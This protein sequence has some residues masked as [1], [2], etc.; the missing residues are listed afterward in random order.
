MPL[1]NRIP[2]AVLCH[3]ESSP[4]LRHGTTFAQ[5]H[6]ADTG[7]PHSPLQLVELERSIAVWKLEL[8]P[9]AGRL[10]ARISRR[11]AALQAPEECGE[12]Q[13]QTVQDRILALTIDGGEPRLG[14]AQFRELRV[15]LA[16]RERDA[17]AR[18]GIAAL[19]EQRVV[20]LAG[21]AQHRHERA[22]LRAGRVEPDFV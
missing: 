9:P 4:K 7:H 13:I 14:F 19:L 3:E 1:E 8:I 20:E 22:L 18:P 12:G 15:L 5:A 10:E 6:R 21:D 11:L 2:A 16:A 17:A